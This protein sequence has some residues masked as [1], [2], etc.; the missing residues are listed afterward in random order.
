MCYAVASQDDTIKPYVGFNMLFD[1]NFLRLSDDVDSLSVTDKTSK[2]E[3]IKQATAGFDL[4]WTISRQHIIVKANINQNWFQNFTSL[5]YLGWNT[6]AQWNWQIGNHVNGEFGYSNIQSLG[7]FDYL[8]GLISNLYNE[9]RY[10]ANVGYLFH[11]NGKIKLDLFRNENKFDDDTRQVNN[12]IEDNAEVNLQYLSPTGSILG[13]RLI[14]TDGQYPQR[15]ISDVGSQDNAY[16]RM[17]YGVTWKWYASSKSRI[18]GLLGYTQ[19]RYA[20]FSVRNFADIV[21]Q[22]KLNWQPSDKTILELSARRDIN[23]YFDVFSN[24]LLTQG[25]WFNLT[26]QLSPKITVMWPMSYQQ[27]QF[28]GN[29]GSNAAGQEQRK[30][31]VSNI[32]LNLMYHP[33]DSISI[34]P[35]LNY[36][37]RESN[38]TDQSRSYETLSAW[39]KLQVDF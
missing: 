12:N 24:F 30:D 11:P 15:P 22:L 14:A 18:D 2:S 28:L 37:R 20:N 17:H 19:Q 5:D 39:I 31:T 29:I 3:F 8:N 34:G 36:E 27:Q 13:L 1:S 26:W 23:Q 16:T 6:G 10:F 4:D 21:A 7:S 38:A 33:S 35:I 25:I 32:G 9:Q